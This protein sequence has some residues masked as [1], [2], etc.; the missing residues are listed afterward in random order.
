MEE[1]IETNICSFCEVSHCFVQ[2]HRDRHMAIA[3]R[4]KL[5]AGNENRR[6]RYYMCRRIAR[7]RFGVLGNGNRVR[8]PRCMEL[9]IKRMCPNE[10]GSSFVGYQDRNNTLN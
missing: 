9:H 2:R 8:V 1:S 3:C 5:R 6:V 10:D 7:D 4:C